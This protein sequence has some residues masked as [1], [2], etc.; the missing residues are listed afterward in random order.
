MENMVTKKPIL[1]KIAMMNVT[2]VLALPQTIVH[3]VLAID[4]SN[5]QTVSKSAVMVFTKKAQLTLVT[6]VLQHVKLAQAKL[7]ATVILVTLE[8]S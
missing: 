6:N 4:S 7:T 8:D 5:K 3:P 2:P 1:V